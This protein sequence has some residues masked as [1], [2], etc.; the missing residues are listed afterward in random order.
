MRKL[1]LEELNRLS[2][3]DFKNASKNKII[4]ILDNVRSAMNVGSVF[5]TAD[6]FLVEEIILTGITAQPPNREIQKTALG[7]TETVDWRYFASTQECI[8]YLKEK[9]CKILAV[10]QS[11]SSIMLPDFEPNGDEKY[12]LIFGNE[13]DGVSYDFIEQCDACIEIPQFGSKHSL[14]IS[15]CAG[16]VIWHFVRTLSGI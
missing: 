13:V 9:K 2:T 16:I 12:A 14:N 3:E 8:E 7:A 11:D 5:R 6:A 4:I 1:K 15:V 10:E